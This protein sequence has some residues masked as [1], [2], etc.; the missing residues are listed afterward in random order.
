MVPGPRSVATGLADDSQVACR[1][2]KEFEEDYARTHDDL[3]TLLIFVSGLIP[4][5][6]VDR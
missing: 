4:D 2:Y 6:C 1:K 3:N 5:S